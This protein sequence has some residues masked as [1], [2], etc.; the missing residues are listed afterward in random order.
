MT[1]T[2]PET[3]FQAL[4][5]AISEGVGIREMT[6]SALNGIIEAHT[7]VLLGALAASNS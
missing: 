2:A 1:L 7:P 5:K 3:V 6:I 4:H